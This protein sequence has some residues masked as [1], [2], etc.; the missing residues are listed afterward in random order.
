M[1]P[2]RWRSS[3]G[4]FGASNWKDSYALLWH[5]NDH[6]TVL[7]R[8]IFLTLYDANICSNHFFPLPSQRVGDITDY[9]RLY[10]QYALDNTY[11][12]FPDLRRCHGT[13]K[14]F[15]CYI[16]ARVT[17]SAKTGTRFCITPFT[18]SKFFASPIEPF[19]DL[20]GAPWRLPLASFARTRD[21]MSGMV[22]YSAEPI[23]VSTPLKQRL[24]REGVQGGKIEVRPLKRA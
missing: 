10:W 13:W 11:K 12:A 4:K 7:S 1:A 2:S 16:I 23:T 5:H 17:K 9:D 15:H 14:I 24:L 21:I 22:P 6:Y 8:R 20:T 19:G 3:Q 18:E